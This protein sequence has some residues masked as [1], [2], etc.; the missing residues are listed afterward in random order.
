[1]R[2]AA[3]VFLLGFQIVTRVVSGA[4]RYEAI[5]LPTDSGD[6]HSVIALNNLNQAIGVA[7]KGSD[8]VY[9]VLWENGLRK[10]LRALSFADGQN[11]TNARPQAINDAG[12]IVGFKNM[13]GHPIAWIL[14][15]G[16]LALL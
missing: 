1:M 4:H 2:V 15:D 8:I 7:S 3:G 9:P 5:P 16:N 10:D 13:A 6:T 11:L 14:Q 12:H